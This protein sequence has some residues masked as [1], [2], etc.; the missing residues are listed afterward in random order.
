MDFR[1]D[2]SSPLRF[3]REF[4]LIFPDPRPMNLPQSAPPEPSLRAPNA[5]AHGRRLAAQRVR[6]ARDRLTST[7]GTRPAFDYELLRQF[8][9][10]RLSASPV[11]LLLIATV[12]FLSSLWTG[13][14][15]AATWTGAVLLIHL[16]IIV[17]CRHFL[18]EGTANIRIRLWRVRFVLLDLFFGLAWTFNLVY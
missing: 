11:I 17:T 12:G 2:L 1:L 15:V 13:T 7:S 18:A 9:Q 3:L 5:L 4:S 8:A 14:T 16:I 10:N 6:E